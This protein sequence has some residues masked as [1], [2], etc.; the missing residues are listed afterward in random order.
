MTLMG[1]ELEAN[2]VNFTVTEQ[3][4]RQTATTHT[5]TYCNYQKSKTD[6]ISKS[7]RG[8]LGGEDESAHIA[9]LSRVEE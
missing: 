8:C 9:A 6:S 7:R 1:G 3:R 5:L 2:E 4:V